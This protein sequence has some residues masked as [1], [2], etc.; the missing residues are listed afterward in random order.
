MTLPK[1]AREELGI[2]GDEGLQVE[3][4]EEEKKDDV[5]EEEEDIDEAQ[6]A[7]KERRKQ[8]KKMNAILFG[9]GKYYLI[10]SFF[11]MI[12]YLKKKKEEFSIV[13]KSYGKELDNVVYEFNKFCS[14]EHPCFN[15][16][17]NTPLVKVDGS[18][19]QKDL[20]FRDPCQR[21]C[22]YRGSNEINQTIMVT[23]SN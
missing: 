12:M 23:G 17:N 9:E 5:N 14:G 8:E 11:R 4:D 20:R 18:K 21:A 6:L 2:T 10:P 13:F 22:I 19:N 16:R 15:G 3:D 1:G 7:E